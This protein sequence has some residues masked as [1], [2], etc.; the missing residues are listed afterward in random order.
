MHRVVVVAFVVACGGRQEPQ[1]AP[2][3][4]A[5][6]NPDVHGGGLSDQVVSAVQGIPMLVRVK[7][8][9]LFDDEMLKAEEIVAAWANKTG[10]SVVPPKQTHAILRRSLRGE[11]AMTGKACGAPL[12]DFQAVE[13]WAPELGARGKIEVG[14]YCSP[15]CSMQ[16]SVSIGTGGEGGTEFFAA[17]FDP[18]KPWQTE[19]AARLPTIA[20]NGGHN[21]HGHLNNPVAV[22]GVPRGNGPDAVL[23]DKTATLTAAESAAAATCLARDRFARVLLGYG[24]SGKLERCEPAPDVLGAGVD[25]ACKALAARVGA[26]N[27]RE[28]I[29][30]SAG[31]GDAPVFSKDKLAVRVI[32]SPTMIPVASEGRSKALTT[33]PA[34]ENWQPPDRDVLNPCFAGAESQAKLEGRASVDFD[35][36]GRATKAAIIATAGTF[37]AQQQS[38]L[39]DVFLQVRAPCPSTAKPQASAEIHVFFDK[40]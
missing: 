36:S 30:V 3:P 17:P 5:D 25:C 20:D 16:V 6:R 14:I 22:G 40:P 27:A 21:Q 2:L 26:P 9:F 19:L 33:D 7:G 39:R 31:G 18:S 28:S 10:V 29:S 11:H 23:D 4:E 37:T 35:A 32:A 8:L 24:A 1:R 38:C 15:D 34:I 12:F 13:R